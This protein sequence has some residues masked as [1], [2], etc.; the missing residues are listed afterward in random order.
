MTTTMRRD[1]PADARGVDSS[2]ARVRFRRRPATRLALLAGLAAVVLSCGSCA[3][4]PQPTSAPSSSPTSSGL[5]VPPLVAGTPAEAKCADASIGKNIGVAEYARRFADIGD[6]LDRTHGVS[7]E[8]RARNRAA[9]EALVLSSSSQ[10]VSSTPAGGQ[11]IFA[12]AICQQFFDVA[13][14]G[15]KKF[16]VPPTGVLSAGY[17]ACDSIKKGSRTSAKPDP[18]GAN[19]SD[20]IAAA[21]GKYLCP[22]L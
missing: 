9:A 14:G 18:G 7:V 21:A 4:T 8:L 12:R 6:A 20:Q 19:A 5:R 17:A 3:S 11:G 10:M 15:P 2:P 16:T 22:Q 13:F 1:R